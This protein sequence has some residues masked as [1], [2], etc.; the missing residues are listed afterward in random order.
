MKKKKFKKVY[1]QP[2]Y[3][4]L[5]FGSFFVFIKKGFR[6]K[7]FETFK[8]TPLPIWVTLWLN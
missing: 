4:W 7:K 3:F 8:G 1:L 2:V 5:F 6:F